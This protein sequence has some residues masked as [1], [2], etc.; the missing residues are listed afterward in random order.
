MEFTILEISPKNPDIEFLHIIEKEGINCFVTLCK[1][2][3]AGTTYDISYFK[4]YLN[5]YLF[6]GVNFTKNVWVELTNCLSTNK[7]VINLIDFIPT[8]N[9]VKMVSKII[10]MYQYTDIEKILLHKKI[11]PYWERDIEKNEIFT[12]LIKSKRLN[13][14]R[15]LRCTETREYTKKWINKYYED[16]KRLKSLASVNIIDVYHLDQKFK[17]II[18]ITEQLLRLFKRGI[19]ME[20]LLEFKLPINGESTYL[21]E[22]FFI[23]HKYLNLS[24]LNVMDIMN[25][26]RSVLEELQE[27]Y[28]SSQMQEDQ[29][30]GNIIKLK[31]DFFTSLL[32]K[33]ENITYDKDICFEFYHEFTIE[34]IANMELTTHEIIDSILS[35]T[36]EFLGNKQH[37]I[38]FRKNIFNVFM[39]ILNTNNLLTSS[40]YIKCKTVTIIASHFDSLETCAKIYVLNN[41]ED[42]VRFISHLYINIAKMDDYDCIIYQMEILH[43]LSPYKQIILETLTHEDSIKFMNNF[44]EIYD[45]FYRGFVKNIYSIYDKKNNY[46]ISEEERTNYIEQK[47]VGLK[48]YQTELLKMDEYLS[49]DE[50]LKKVTH[51]GLRD[52]FVTI[53]GYKMEVFLGKDRSRLV[54]NED[55]IYFNSLIHLKNIY[56]VF[57]I[58]YKNDDF[59]KALVLETRYFKTHYIQKMLNTLLKKN[60]ILSRESDEISTLCTFIDTER[61]KQNSVD[62]E[63]IPEELL[64]PIMGTLIEN[65][66]V[67]PGTFTVMEKD[68]ILRHLMNNQEN[69][70]TREKL[71]VEE[72]ERY[73]KLEEI[74]EFIL[75]FKQRLCDRR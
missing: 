6:G 26:I 2:I 43:L 69:P 29:E 5:N 72:L 39:N 28:A 13:L 57:Y 49:Y 63:N 10:Q 20:K 17:E 70:F 62:E 44:L 60:I 18:Y 67:L 21:N 48:W 34:W 8:D 9:K 74:Q 36:L 40:N 50:L 68:V 4:N 66:I 15:F 45:Y 32:S 1:N 25:N 73:N 51:V 42:F 12:K 58:L 22:L 37:T 31:I 3:N 38:Y 56:T 23:T 65:P 75:K 11:L 41:L 7:D 59:K 53:I 14:Y 64:D 24:I 46:S 19:T 47:K 55:N 16:N 27:S 30:L 52:K 54:I 71:T 61:V 35:N 33:L